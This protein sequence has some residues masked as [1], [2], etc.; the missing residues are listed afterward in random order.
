MEQL[1][2]ILDFA[3]VMGAAAV[4][5]LVL[6]RF[7]LPLAPGYIISGLILSTLSTSYGLIQN[8]TTIEVMAQLG[9]VLLL[10]TIGLQFNIGKL[11]K[12]GLL[13]IFIGCIEISICLTVGYWLGILLGWAPIEAI[14]L[15]GVMSISST[16][17]IVK[18]LQAFKAP[19]RPHLNIILGVLIVEDAVAII[20]ITFFSS[21]QEGMSLT[22]LEAVQ[23]GFKILLFAV[24][25]IAIGMYLFPS[26]VDRVA[27]MR[28]TEVLIITILGMC[29]GM[30]AFAQVLGFSASIGAFLMGV[31]VGSSKSSNI[32]N[33][34][35]R[36]IRDFF[37]ALF[38][39]TIGFFVTP[40]DLWYALPVA[41]LIII[42]FL[43]IKFSA[44]T[45][46]SVM[47]GRHRAHA[48]R[49]G[50]GMMAM[51]E[52]SFVIAQ[53]SITSGVVHKP[54]LAIAVVAS[55]ATSAMLPFIVRSGDGLISRILKED[56][57]KLQ[58]YCNLTAGWFE[59]LSSRI[60]GKLVE[61]VRKFVL[62]TF[63]SIVIIALVI[64]G[65][66]AVEPHVSVL[67]S[68]MGMDPF[69]VWIIIL[70]V[71]VLLLLAQAVIIARRVKIFVERLS[72]NIVRSSESA[73]VVGRS[74]VRHLLHNFIGLVLAVVLMAFLTLFLPM[75]PIPLTFIGVATIFFFVMAVWII[76]DSI[77]HLNRRVENVLH[78]SF[79]GQRATIKKDIKSPFAPPS[80]KR[81]I[82]KKDRCRR[83]RKIR[84]QRKT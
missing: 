73:R 17:I 32:I 6:N 45:L 26:F 53:I 71:A 30:A 49:I 68:W 52:F 61:A 10:F 69:N 78:S 22:L 64:T 51:G 44:V 9:M 29:F 54:L 31:I 55:F 46:A 33:R 84:K 48:L 57:G 20:L 81:K 40:E 4:V 7:G 42:M 38:F 2:P 23:I 16:V 12:A 58:T 21:I 36:S 25:S 56:P 67:S 39:I 34:Q 1:A 28:S 76:E 63:V 27:A 66:T 11:R 59:R 80:V 62:K 65:I 72:A 75:F 8:F 3:L 35:V 19:W 37:I 83:R 24:V 43:V 79:K 70:V 14:A 77:V 41:V 82:V 47:G 18:T 15:G 74:V 60:T 50:F 13:V 5:A